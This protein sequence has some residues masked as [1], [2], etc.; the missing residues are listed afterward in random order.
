MRQPARR[1]AVVGA[2]LALL[3]FLLY[4]P[5]LR[6]Q[7]VYDAQMQI[8]QDDF[9]HTPSNLWDVLTFR[10]MA[11]DVLD[12]NR[13]VH[14][15]SLM[16]DSL[17]WG[18]DPL[19]FH[20]TSILL[21][22]ANV[23][24]LFLLLRR[25][26]EQYLQMR[27][28]E[29]AE[30]G[31]LVSATIGAALFAVHPL[32]TEA[33]AEPSYREDLLSCFFM[34]WALVL[35]SEWPARW[36]GKP[37]AIAVGIFLCTLWSIGSKEI[38]ASVTAI[39]GIYWLTMRWRAPRLNW[40]GLLFGCGV[41]ALIFTAARFFFEPKNSVIFLTKPQYLGGSFG[42]ML[43]LQPRVWFLYLLHV[44]WPSRL[45]ADYTM[46]SLK[47][48]ALGWA[49]AGLSVL[50]VFQ[51][52]SA[53]FN[54]VLIL[55]T[56]LF[57]L[58]LLPA[59][60]LFPQ[61]RPV[62]DRYMYTP[63]TGMGCA[64]AAI[65]AWLWWNRTAV[66][67]V[68]VLSGTCLIACVPLCVM[69]QRVFSNSLNLWQD[70]LAKDPDSWTA[71]DNLGWALYEAGDDAKAIENFQKA[72]NLTRGTNPDPWVGAAL[73]LER[74][75]NYERAE[76]AMGKAIQIDKEFADADLLWK[77]HSITKAQAE[78][79]RPILRRIQQSNTLK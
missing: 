62:A 63:M 65:V 38:G 18:R 75:G 16:I 39:L 48:I 44:L 14:L 28:S 37:L 4:S 73:A 45:S 42:A 72:L 12:F 31:A 54:R 9:I 43:H 32:C 77:K 2:A 24:L 66:K 36:R 57:W 23:V 34:L 41:I 53:C 19:G 10:V 27:K 52:L 40:I 79:A 6:S 22:T 5:S 26:I 30:K 51:L 59:S 21:H 20:L 60:N 61:Y 70:T 49:L 69:H 55:S 17:I 78:R 74:V 3:T 71:A 50:L 7:F 47:D 11:R 8:E 35:A 33:V 58:T 25:W 1:I 64:L 15:A 13:P 29:N 67:I 56:A 46:Y 76:W 68:C